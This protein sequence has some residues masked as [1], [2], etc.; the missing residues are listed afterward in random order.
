MKLKNLDELEKKASGNSRPDFARL[1]GALMFALIVFIYAAT[2]AASFAS[3][4]PYAPILLVMAALFG[5][6]MAMNIG[7]NDVANNMGPV[8]GSKAL[9]MGGAIATAAVFEALGAVI[10]G[11]DVVSTVKSGII[12]PLAVGDAEVFVRIMACALLAGAI[13]LN[14]ATAI[15]APVSTTHSIVGAVMGAGIVGGG[16]GAVHW[17]TMGAIVSSWVISPALGG[18][19]AAVMLYTIKRTITYRREMTKAA[20]QVVPLLNALMAWTFGTYMLIKGFGALIKMD[21]ALAALCAGIF[22]AFVYLFSRRRVNRTTLRSENSKDAVNRLF[23]L[24]L[25]FAAALLSFAHGAND[26]ANAI[27]PLAA[28]DET[29]RSAIVVSQTPIPLWIMMI[30]ALGLAVGLALYGPKLIKT[31]GGEIT[32]LDKMRAYCVALASALT[33]I[34]ASQLGLP[35]STTHVAIG[36][37]F[38]VGFLREYLKSSHAKML[39]LI[40]QAHEGEARSR[41]EAYIARYKTAPMEKKAIMLKAMKKKAEQKEANQPRFSK[42]ERKALKKEYKKELVKRSAMAKIVAAWIV[43]VP[44]TALLS[45]ILFVIAGLAF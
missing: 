32:D 5:A 2:Q 20:A 22:A 23:G 42:K 21:F 8:V 44:A 33:V 10:A 41:V 9:T 31:V 12:D 16:F 37:I 4:A 38:G 39:E 11:G 19:L 35:V 26:V 17:E 43:T 18:A 34:L 45:A 6:Y 25:I 13:W 29:L 28:I 27:G 36:A 15:G 1:G 7:A 40:I 3:N 14:I 30:G 24:P